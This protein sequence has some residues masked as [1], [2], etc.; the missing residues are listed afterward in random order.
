VSEGLHIEDADL[1][2]L[3][4]GVHRFKNMPLPD[5]VARLADELLAKEA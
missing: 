5:E 1:E 2:G 3:P 4:A